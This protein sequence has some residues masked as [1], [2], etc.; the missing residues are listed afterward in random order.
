M[1]EEGEQ[2]SQWRKDYENYKMIERMQ[3]DGSHDMFE[4][5]D[6]SDLDEEEPYF[7]NPDDKIHSPQITGLTAIGLLHTYVQT[8]PHDKFTKLQPYFEF[9]KRNILDSR[10]RLI[11]G[12]SG[13]CSSKGK[14]IA[15]LHMPHMTPYREPIP[16]KCHKS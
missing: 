12:L 8:V 16:G 14:F 3:I 15:T 13:G 10:E 5:E 1:T 2:T 9:E 11:A 6:D 7:A 4:D